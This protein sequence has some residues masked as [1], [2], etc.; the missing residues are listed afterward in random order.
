VSSVVLVSTT[1]TAW[2]FIVCLTRFVVP[3]TPVSGA[4]YEANL[5][6]GDERWFK[7]KDEFA[8]YFCR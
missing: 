5:G 6:V 3:V 1:L 2:D 8:I 7:R 4:A